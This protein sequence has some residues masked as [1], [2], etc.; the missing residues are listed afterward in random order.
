M[1]ANE[2]QQ[3]KLENN[4]EPRERQTNEDRVYEMDV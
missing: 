2:W 1:V 4:L 3:S